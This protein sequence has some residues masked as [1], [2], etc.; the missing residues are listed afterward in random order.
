MEPHD[1]PRSVK[2]SVMVDASH[3]DT[4]GVVGIGMVFFE[5]DKRRRNGP[6]I[7]RLAEAY[8]DVPA[9]QMEEFAVFRALEIARERSSQHVKVRSDYNAMR[10]RLKADHRSGSGHGT[11][12]LHG[13]VLLLARTFTET[14]FAYQPRKKNQAA[15]AL[16]RMAAKTLPAVT[17]PDVFQP[18]AQSQRPASM[19][20]SQTV[21]DRTFFS[22][23]GA[24]P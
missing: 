23:D 16:A 12:S 3:D 5:T 8:C 11:G 1:G 14:K 18:G 20:R 22:D 7:A 13:R 17:R 24:E 21:Y 15:H 4:R 10:R 2:L 19:R 9:G 6:V